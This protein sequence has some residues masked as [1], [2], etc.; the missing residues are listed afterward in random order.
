MDLSP[1]LRNPAPWPFFLAHFSLLFPNSVKA[2]Y[3]LTTCI[4]SFATYDI[5]WTWASSTFG[6]LSLISRN[7]FGGTNFQ[8]LLDCETV[9]FFLCCFLSFVLSLSVSIVFLDVF[10]ASLPSRTQEYLFQA[11][12]IWKGR[13]FTCCSIWKGR[14]I[15][16]LG[17]WKGPKG[18]TN[19]FYGFI[20]SRKRSIFVIDC[21]LSDNAFTAV[22]RDAKF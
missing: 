15:F 13:D 12:G 9:I 16:H 19:E 2:C 4:P 17:L 21:Y 11:S 1:S 8:L 7:R 18:R 5:Y 10:F 3:G 14:E 20:K 22:K 6:A